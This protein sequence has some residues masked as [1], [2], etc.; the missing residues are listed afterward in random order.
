MAR[1]YDCRAEEVAVRVVMS[2]ERQR[3]EGHVGI[4][5]GKLRSGPPGVAADPVC[6][7]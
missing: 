6:A 4:A 1:T 2:D 5:I 3:H 7:G